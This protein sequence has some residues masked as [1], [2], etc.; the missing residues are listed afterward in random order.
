[1]GGYGRS[2]AEKGGG[3]VG[4]SNRGYMMKVRLTGWEKAE[5]E[6]M[7]KEA[8]VSVSEYFRLSVFPNVEKRELSVR[9]QKLRKGRVRKP[10]L[11]V[12]GTRPEDGE[13]VS[14]SGRIEEGGV[15]VPPGTVEMGKPVMNGKHRLCERCRRMGF[16]VCRS[17][18]AS[19]E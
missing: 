11:G 10:V 19:W 17:N 18:C 2:F 12:I 5:A 16:T 7:A 6:R 8:G 1:M 4:K 14:S 9:L 15:T 13:K 3:E